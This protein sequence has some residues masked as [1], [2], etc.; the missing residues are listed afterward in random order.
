[1]FTVASLKD[2]PQEIRDQAMQAHNIPDD[3]IVPVVM[4]EAEVYA[5][6]LSICLKAM[7]AYNLLASS[8]N[9]ERDGIVNLVNQA[10]KD[11]FRSEIQWSLDWCMAVMEELG[12]SSEKQAKRQMWE[13]RRL[14]KA[15]LYEKTYMG[16]VD[17][18]IGAQLKIQNVEG[19]NKVKSF[20]LDHLTQLD[21]DPY[22]KG[23]TDCV[24]FMKKAAKAA[25][26][27]VDQ[28]V[29]KD[30]E[31]DEEEILFT[32]LWRYVCYFANQLA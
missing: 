10:E 9:I 8:T 13:R 23:Y 22:I 17:L 6:K 12:K 27:V 4:E 31:G 28:E 21:V 2:A 15:L 5:T 7:N 3:A 14:G 19:I 1:M 24:D 11:L 29:D 32:T 18:V 25:G 30:G 26:V 20:V 16:R